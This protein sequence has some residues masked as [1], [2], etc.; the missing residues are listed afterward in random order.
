[1]ADLKLLK[2]LCALR[3]ISGCED[4]VRERIIE[5]IKPY[6]SSF[7][8][9][10]LGNLI[11]EKKGKKRSAKSVMLDAHMD[12]VGMIVTHIDGNGQLHFSTVGGI[13]EK[14]IAGV[15]VEIGE[16]AVA[17]VVGVKPT[18]L[19]KADERKKA[20][21]VDSLT[22]DIGA[23][24]KEEAEKYVSVGDDVTFISPIYENGEIIRAKALDDRAGCC[25]LVELI[26]KELEYDLTFV[27]SVQEEVGLCGAKTATFSVK[28]DAA[29]VLETTTASDLAGIASEKQ[30]C[31]V[32]NG[33]VISFMDKRTIYDRKYYELAFRVAQ[34]CNASAQAKE[35]VAGGNNA[36]AIHSSASGVR[37]VAVSLPCR[38]LHA[39]IGMISLK[40]YD[41]ALA[42]VENLAS[43]IASGE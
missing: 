5:E 12:E 34:Q 42:I 3:G 37:T 27:F 22:I 36:G 13:D 9:D 43:T 30:V 19:C 11:V 31:K 18:H 39:P 7:R 29:I 20:V 41:S 21:P 35:A 32:G 4:K 28:P 6:A 2:D 23:S 24:S 40:D 25:M 38:Y 1:M 33:A 8:V 15:G 17:G 10:G 16:N 26:R 14:V